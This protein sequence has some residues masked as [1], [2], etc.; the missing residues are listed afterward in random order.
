[1][2][3]CYLLLHLKIATK[4]SGLKEHTYYLSFSGSGIRTQLHLTLSLAAVEVLPGLGLICRLSWS[5]IHLHAH[6]LL[7]AGS[8][9]S[10]VVGLRAFLIQDISAL[11]D[12][13]VLHCIIGAQLGCLGGGRVF[14]AQAWTWWHP[15]FSDCMGQNSATWPLV[16][17]QGYRAA[18]T[19][20]PRRKR[21]GTLGTVLQP[22]P[23][24]G[25]HR[26]EWD[27]SCVNLTAPQVPR[28]LPNQ[29]FWVC[30]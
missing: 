7:L 30:L 27:V 9:S 17:W 12:R 3:I 19:C 15:F 18:R 25:V 8:S 1:M 14:K 13:G 29:Y 5:R 10:W 4:L 26:T 20:G 28:E 16:W 23:H 11:Y 6:S 22:L 2:N 21:T 24:T